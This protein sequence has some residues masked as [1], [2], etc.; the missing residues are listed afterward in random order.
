MLL[1]LSLRTRRL[2][3]AQ[4]PKESKNKFSP[5][6]IPTSRRKRH[7]WPKDSSENLLGK[8]LRKMHPSHKESLTG[9]KSKPSWRQP[10]PSGKHLQL[11]WRDGTSWRSWIATTSRGFLE[12]MCSTKIIPLWISPKICRPVLERM[13][14]VFIS[15]PWTKKASLMVWAASPVIATRAF[16]K[17]N[18]ERAI[19][20]V[21]FAK[22]SMMAATESVRPQMTLGIA[23]R[24][25]TQ[26]ASSSMN[27]I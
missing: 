20:M 18:S 22:F 13:V 3:K 24:G 27:K 11:P 2:Q 8:N 21:T 12:N 6:C 9:K 17:D 1:S 5:A 10:R 4:I 26:M 7:N 14:P 19:F 25:T 15:E 16:L 23:I